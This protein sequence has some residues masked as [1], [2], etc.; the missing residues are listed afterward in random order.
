MRRYPIRLGFTPLGHKVQEGDGKT[1]Q[2]SYVI[3]AIHKAHFISS[4]IS[5]T[6]ML[7]IS[8]RQHN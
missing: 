5:P 1:P 6:P 2:G 4:C 7:L 3:G 8:K